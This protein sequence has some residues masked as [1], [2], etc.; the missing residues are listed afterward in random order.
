MLFMSS[1][2]ENMLEIIENMMSNSHIKPESH[3]V[4]II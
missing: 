4:D 1:N 2:S 3:A